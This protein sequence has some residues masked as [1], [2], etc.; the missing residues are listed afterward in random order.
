MKA[1]KDATVAKMDK[2]HEHSPGMQ[3]SI[4]TSADLTALE[5]ELDLKTNHQQLVKAEHK[6]TSCRKRL[7]RVGTVQKSNTRRIGTL[8]AP[9]EIENTCRDV[10]EESLLKVE[11]E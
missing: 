6:A 4:E 3:E 1:S 2:N 10:V 7:E 5:K 8:W 11:G 9:Q